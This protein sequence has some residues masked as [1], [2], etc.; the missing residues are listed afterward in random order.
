MDELAEI[1]G[2]SKKTIYNH[3]GSRENLMETIILTYMKTFLN[4]ITELFAA[5]DKTIIDKI[6]AAFT[7]VYSYYETIDKPVEEDINVARIFNSPECHQLNENIR[8]LIYKMAQEGRKQ[9]IIKEGIDLN[10]F[11]YFFFNITSSLIRWKRPDNVT[12][13]KRELLVMTFTIVFNGFLTP[14]A[15]EELTMENSPLL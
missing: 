7:W 4:N 1:I 11:S 9:G 12:F 8:E 2:I 5:E 15:M 14:E 10:M 3:F 6:K 13:T